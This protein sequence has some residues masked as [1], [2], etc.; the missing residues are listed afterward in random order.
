MKTP[1][2]NSAESV[3]ARLL[4]LAKHDGEDFQ[5]MLSNYAAE[6]ILYRL[7]ASTY[8]NH[9]VLRGAFLFRVWLGELHRPTKDLHLLGS[10]SSDMAAVAT[11]VQDLARIPSN[12]GI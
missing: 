4:A 3:R 6:R 11:F 5:S 9:F 1:K 7:G 8:R 12:D 10:G 2:Y